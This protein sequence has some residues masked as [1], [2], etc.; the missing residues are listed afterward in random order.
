MERSFV[1]RRDLLVSLT[2]VAALLAGGGLQSIE[3]SAAAADPTTTWLD[4]RDQRQWA[5]TGSWTHASGETWSA[6]NEGGSE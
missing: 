1:K 5:Y 6:G 3:P 2:V 4:D